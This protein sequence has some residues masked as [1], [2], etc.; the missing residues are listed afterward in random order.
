MDRHARAWSD[1]RTASLRP[2]TPVHPWVP[3]G[4]GK[5]RGSCAC[6]SLRPAASLRAARGGTPSRGRSA[7][8]GQAPPPGCSIIRVVH[9]VLGGL[10]TDRRS[11]RPNRSSVRRSPRLTSSL[12]KFESARASA[13]V[14]ATIAIPPRAIAPMS[15]A[16]PGLTRRRIVSFSLQNLSS[17]QQFRTNLRNRL[18]APALRL[19]YVEIVRN[20]LIE[21][22]Q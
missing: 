22:C 2:P 5:R 8:A 17:R 1:E 13:A 6:P 12:S 3:R 20:S 14:P 21:A 9:R 7:E 16:L 15:T 11:P 19:H 4:A 18:Q 10:S